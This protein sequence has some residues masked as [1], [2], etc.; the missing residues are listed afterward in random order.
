MRE[1]QLCAASTSTLF[2]GYLHKLKTNHDWVVV[3][4]QNVKVIEITM[5]FT[6]QFCL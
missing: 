2:T 5:L 6:E 1:T 4:L 3:V